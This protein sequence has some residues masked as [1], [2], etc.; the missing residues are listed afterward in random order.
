MVKTPDF[1]L[2]KQSSWPW[3]E[4]LERAGVASSGE[5]SWWLKCVLEATVPPSGSLEV[6]LHV[7]DVLVDDVFKL[8][9]KH[10]G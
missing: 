9:L 8:V 7:K 1:L 10:G 6:R 4:L 3:L 5:D 2:D